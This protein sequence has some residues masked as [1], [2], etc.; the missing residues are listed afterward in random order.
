MD[1]PSAAD[2]DRGMQAIAQLGEVMPDQADRRVRDIY[3]DLKQSLRVPF[4]NFVFRV[5]AQEPD[6]LE[7]EWRRVRSIVRTAEFE[8]L[9]DE[10]R[11]RGLPATRPDAAGVEWATLGPLERITAFTDSIHYVL[12]KLLLI[13]TI[14]SER[15]AAGDRLRELPPTAAA[16]EIPGGPAAGT[17]GAPLVDPQQASGRLAELFAEIRTRHGH[18]GVASYYRGL[19]NWPEF[20]DALWTRV[21]PLVGSEEYHRSRETLTE[22]AASMSRR[23][24]SGGPAENG[25]SSPP[26]GTESSFLR[27]RRQ[28]EIASALAVFRLKLIPDLLIDVCLI[29]AMFEGPE[30]AME[31][32]FSSASGEKQ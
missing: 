6:Y 24:F 15:L 25:S 16:A 11:G 7:S 13:A 30:A 3:D 19:G 18:P 29:K 4:V 20:L 1:H 17:A 22:T 2:L 27:P 21:A 31:S 14:F 8:R 23:F 9:A 26:E 12:P 32:R 10:L 5:L 28:E